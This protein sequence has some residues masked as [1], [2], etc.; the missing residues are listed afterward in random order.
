MRMWTYSEHFFLF[1][2]RATFVC[3]SPGYISA[4]GQF[5]DFRF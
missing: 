5:H 2:R 3:V 1:V 4:I